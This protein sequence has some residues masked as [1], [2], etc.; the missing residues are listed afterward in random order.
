MVTTLLVRDQQAHQTYLAAGLNPAEPAYGNA[1][2]GLA[3]FFAVHGGRA[4]AMRDA[5]GLLYRELRQQAMLMA[6]IDDFRLLGFV[7]LACMPFLLFF[8]KGERRQQGKME[9]HGE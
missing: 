3:G 2:R 7:S 4:G 9:V 8:Q 1:L 5:M 6:Y